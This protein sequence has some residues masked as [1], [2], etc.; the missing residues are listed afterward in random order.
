MEG[1]GCCRVLVVTPGKEGRVRLAG[2]SSWNLGTYLMRWVLLTV[3]TLL[4]DVG[5]AAVRL[6]LHCISR[7]QGGAYAA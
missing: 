7:G 5:L 3:V 6:T 1:A 4:P 2:M